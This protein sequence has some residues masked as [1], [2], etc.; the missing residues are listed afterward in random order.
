VGE[1]G[2]GLIGRPMPFEKKIRKCGKK[3]Y[4]EKNRK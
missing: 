3:E 2:G 1:G 4:E